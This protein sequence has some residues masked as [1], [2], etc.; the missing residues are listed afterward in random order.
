MCRRYVDRSCELLLLRPYWNY[1]DLKM[2][3][4]D[5]CVGQTPKSSNIGCYRQMKKDR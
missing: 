2:V 4:V 1:Y 3:G 5:G